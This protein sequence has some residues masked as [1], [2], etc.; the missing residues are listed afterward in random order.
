MNFT[1][2][3]TLLSSFHMEVGKCNPHELYKILEDIKPDVIFEELPAHIFHSIYS[4]KRPPQTVESRA[5]SVYIRNYGVKHF[6]VDTYEFDLHELFSEYDFIVEL[7]ESYNKVFEKLIKSVSD[8]GFNFL[9]SPACTELISELKSLELKVLKENA[10]KILLEKYQQET[11]IH[12]LRETE[13]LN[14]I[15]NYS[16]KY[17]YNNAILICGTDHKKGIMEKLTNFKKE[18]KWNSKWNFYNAY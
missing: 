16:I 7:S 15:Y 8:F 6:P 11:F 17:P 12:D 10:P 2:N 4:G 13:I 5:I 1:S 14:N 18:M 9:N 3:I